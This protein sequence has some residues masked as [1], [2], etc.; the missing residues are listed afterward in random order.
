MGK[1]VRRGMSF[2]EMWLNSALIALLPG[3]ATG[4]QKAHSARVRFLLNDLNSH[5]ILLKPVIPGY[6]AQ[7]TVTC[8]PINA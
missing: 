1:D 2:A 5:W 4:H 7:I 8:E 6:T 3:K